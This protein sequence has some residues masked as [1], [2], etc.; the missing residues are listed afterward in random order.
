MNVYDSQAMARVLAPHGFELAQ[1]K[2]NADCLLVNTC[3]I[4]EKAEQK[5]YSYLGRLVGLKA[6]KPDIIIGVGG[7]VAQ[8]EAKNILN[9]VPHVDLVFGTHAINRLP[10]LVEK[11]EKTR[12]RVVD[13]GLITEFQ[14]LDAPMEP[15]LPGP[16]AFVTI[17]SGCDNYC[18]YC[19]VPYVR[20]REMSRNSHAICEEIREMAARG[21]REVTLLGQNVNSYGNKQ[22]PESFTGLLNK[23]HEIKEIKRIRFTT[24]HPK[25]IPNELIR[26]FSEMPK[27]CKHIHLPVQS[28]SDKILKKMNRGYTRK[29]YLE[30]I[31]ALRAACPQITITTDIIVG[32]PSE[33]D[34]DFRQT[35]DLIKEADFSSLFAFKYS[36]RP[37]APAAKFKDKVSLDE[38]KQRLAQILDVSTAMTRARHQ[39]MVGAIHTVLVEGVGKNNPGQWRGRTSGHTTVNF[40]MQSGREL[41]GKLVDVK[42]E[43][44]YSHSLLGRIIKE[45]HCRKPGMEVSHAA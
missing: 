39:A 44:G 24:S 16:T 11:V 10:A 36:D 4:R 29:N 13:T 14:E 25:D 15:A 37:L 31:H 42:I 28:G 33:T 23:V 34:E 38:K 21:V 9:R 7:C 45:K 32:F 1:S 19:V 20:G 41:T 27:L 18:T 6:N 17:M 22:G 3:A 43:K 26:A 40:T 2:K 5:V 35:M 12:A 8:H 30:K